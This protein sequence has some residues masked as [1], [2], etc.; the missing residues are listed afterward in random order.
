MESLP[1]WRTGECYTGQAH[2]EKIG[3]ILVVEYVRLR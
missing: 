2:A 1:E 3:E